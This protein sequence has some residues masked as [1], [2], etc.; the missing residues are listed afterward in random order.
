MKVPSRFLAPFLF[1][2]LVLLA[3]CSLLRRPGTGDISFRLH[4]KGDEDLDLHVQE[5][6]GDAIYFMHRKTESGGEL[7]VD[8]NAAPDRLCWTPIENVYWPVGRAAEGSYTYW[9]EMFE[10]PQAQPS[11][12]FTLEVLLGRKVV[13][14]ETGTI[15]LLAKS[16]KKYQFN[17]Q[18]P[19]GM[20]RS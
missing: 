14:T 13:H 11:V 18:R 7:D 16:S 19:P 1:A 3:G 9:V 8:C 5:P 12:P 10:H 4:W 20:G 2:I 17:F 15:G 6:A